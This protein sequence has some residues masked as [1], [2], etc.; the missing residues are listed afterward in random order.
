MYSF[1]IFFDYNGMVLAE[2]LSSSDVRCLVLQFSTSSGFVLF[3]S[4][5]V[6]FFGFWSV[7]IWRYWF[8]LAL[9][10]SEISAHL[11]WICLLFACT[12]SNFPCRP[13]FVPFSSNFFSYDHSPKKYFDFSRHEFYFQCQI[14]VLPPWQTVNW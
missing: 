2:N 11:R 9:C 5:C 12:G 13:A 4:N 1:V 10:R 6:P 8:L 3:N 7:W 14:S